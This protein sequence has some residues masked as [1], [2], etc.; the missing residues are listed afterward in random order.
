LYL[1]YGVAGIRGEA[2]RGFP[3]VLLGLQ[4]LWEEDARGDVNQA[5][6]HTL[7]ALMAETQDTNILWRGGLEKL[8]AVQ[9]M[10]ARILELDGTTTPAGK[11]ALAEL[12]SYCL[13]HRLSPGGSADILSIALF[14]HLLLTLDE[15]TPA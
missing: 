6:L 15:R 12:Q 10:A 2:E 4:R 7:I 5:T 8:Y 3:H 13:T 11:A 1:R 14:F 9:S